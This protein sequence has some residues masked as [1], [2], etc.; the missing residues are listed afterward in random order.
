MGEAVLVLA[1]AV[2]PRVL[3]LGGTF[4]V[5]D[6][7]LYWDWANQF[8][9][10]LLHRDWEA[11]LIRKAYPLVTVMWVQALALGVF[12]LWSWLVGSGMPSAY[13]QLALNRPL[14][15]ELLA[16]RRLPMALANA[17]VVAIIYLY[18][19]KLFGRRV[20]LFAT[21][22]MGLDPF[23]LSDA[24]TMRGDSLM[25]GLM[26][27]AVLSLLMFG[28][29]QNWWQLVFSA[30][31]ASLALLTKMSAAP[32]VVFG[33]ALL[34]GR[35]VMRAY[36]TDSETRAGRLYS[37][38]QEGLRPFLVWFSL[39]ILT[40]L[41]LWPA[42]WASPARVLEA[43]REYAASSLD[44]RLNYFLGRLT[45]TDLLPFFYPISFLFRASPLTLVGLG[46]FLGAAIRATHRWR[47][48]GASLG[49]KEIELSLLAA[50]GLTYVG[51]MTLGLLKRSWY[52][53]PCFPIAMVLA[54]SGWSWLVD[55]VRQLGDTGTR[56]LVRSTIASAVVGGMLATQIVQAFPVHP[57]YYTYWNPLATRKFV[58]YLEMLDWG[59]GSSLAAQWLNAQPSA[60]ELRVAVRPTL[61]EFRPVFKG[62]VVSFT[63][64]QPWV[65]ADY[66]VIRQEHVQMQKHD[67]SE[68]TYLQ[69]LPVAHTITL[70]GVDHGWI[71]QG[72]AA[73]SAAGS[74]L[75][76][77]ATLLGY[78][79][80]PSQVSAGQITR[81]KLY[82]RNEGQYA[83]DRFFVRLVDSDGYS[84]ADDT[85]RP[86]PGFEE[87]FRTREAI[88]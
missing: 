19:R 6:E 9:Q 33:A 55:R 78:E 8:V 10:G 70:N 49:R 28:R 57:Y 82:F 42:L 12:W 72:P 44:G 39:V 18:A 83:S 51:V 79:V 50:Y 41:V 47:R 73:Q 4:V 11:T 76:G 58:P 34:L 66:I 27:L 87:A 3:T 48:Y 88:V 26:A 71:Y 46:L 52:V 40:F 59:I 16:Q 43:M 2:I 32:V 5:N 7:T 60:D 74:Q 61:R 1:L 21:V 64:G 69:Q 75:A 17:G 45:H 62:D 31:T 35:G 80:R 15:F 25:S 67:S 77:K 81:V 23:Y 56:G 30:L 38:W 84:W 85:V 53:L 24:R 36:S 68:L 29:R 13:D 63:Q 65:Q 54:A 37:F 86:R 22:L 14:D 20:A